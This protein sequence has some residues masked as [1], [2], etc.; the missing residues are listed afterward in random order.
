MLIDFGLA[1]IAPFCD[2][3]GV[4]REFM[5]TANQIGRLIDFGIYGI[6][7]AGLVVSVVLG[8]F[9][10][11]TFPAP[12]SGWAH[13]FS[14]AMLFSLVPTGAL[15]V[16]R[17]NQLT[18]DRTPRDVAKSMYS[19]CPPWMRTAT[20]SLMVVGLSLFFLPA[21][22]ELCGYI[23]HNDGTS[24]PSTTPGGFGLMAYSAFIAQL[25]SAAAIAGKTRNDQG[26]ATA[27]HR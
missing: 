1:A 6:S 25:Y 17:Y 19:G 24:F 4:R 5:S 3:I 22:F 21:V 13:S 16:C 14:K 7:T 2:N 8:G 18:Y 27:P 12:L 23:P 9:G 11:L 20:Y 15:F 10:L 26:A